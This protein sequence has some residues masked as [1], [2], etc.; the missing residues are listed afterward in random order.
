MA[1]KHLAISRWP[2]VEDSKAAALY[3]KPSPRIVANFRVA[4]L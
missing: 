2:V 3:I 1:V 4:L